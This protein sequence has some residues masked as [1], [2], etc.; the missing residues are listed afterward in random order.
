MTLDI[1][2]YGC[3]LDIAADGSH[4]DRARELEAAGFDALW[5]A[6]GRLDSL[7]RVHEV[8]E[9]TQRIRVV[10][11][12]VPLGVFGDDA[13]AGLHA[14][15]GRRSPGR[16]VLGLGGPQQ[17]RSLAALARHLD[18]LDRLGVPAGERVLAALGPRK[19]AVAR[20][21]AAGAMTLL[22][23][24]DGT[25]QARRRLGSAAVLA[26]DQFAV[27]VDDLERVRKIAAPTIGFLLSVDG[28]RLHLRRLGFTDDEIDRHDDRFLDAVVAWGD[29]DAIAA[30]AADHLAAGAD[31]V[32]LTFLPAGGGPGPVASGGAVLA[33]LRGGRA[34]G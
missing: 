9:A 5:L 8:V 30:R 33:A 25:A 22:T 20:E 31:H 32:A 19:T 26:V 11:A 15:L 12:V 14:D 13:I 34:A 10:T 7:E 21:R 28:Y 2:T 17:P 24:V 1:G 29:A 23:T 3:A 4:L 6:G 16:L 18:A 27:A